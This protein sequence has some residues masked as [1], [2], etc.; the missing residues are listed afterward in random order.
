MPLFYVKNT[1]CLLKEDM[2]VEISKYEQ[3]LAMLSEF[4]YIFD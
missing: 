2:G 4:L 3:N 1:V